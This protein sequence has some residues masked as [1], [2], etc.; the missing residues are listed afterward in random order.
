[1]LTSQAVGYLLVAATALHAGFQLVV[2]FLVYPAFAEVPADDWARYHA[3]HSRRITGVVVVVYGLAM[4]A[5]AGVLVTSTWQVG[6]LVSVA[7][8][9]LAVLVTMTVAA[10]AHGRLGRGRSERDLATLVAADRFRLGAAVLAA[11]AAL[12]A[13]VG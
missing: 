5:A 3:A 13:T 1:V 9:G 6:T 12:A 2:T 10:P 7:A 4:L 8:T 11:V